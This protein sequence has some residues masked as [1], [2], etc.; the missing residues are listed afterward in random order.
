MGINNRVDFEDFLENRGIMEWERNTCIQAL[1]QPDSSE[2]DD[3]LRR[4]WFAY[5][6]RYEKW[7]RNYAMDTFI[8]EAFPDIHREWERY[9]TARDSRVTSPEIKRYCKEWLRWKWEHSIDHP[10]SVLFDNCWYYDYKGFYDFESECWTD[11][12][13]FENFEQLQDY[14][15]CEANLISKIE[16]EEGANEELSS[17]AVSQAQD[18]AI[19]ELK[20]L[21]M[22]VDCAYREA[23]MRHWQG[24]L[25]HLRKIKVKD[26]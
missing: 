18:I 8:L 2:C 5:F 17:V 26:S 13:A 25:S 14:I 21:E 3:V 12:R 11:V 9:I 22:S 4:I 23:N 24:V 10:I 19:H 7:E 20:A 15:K 1:E 6:P 16:I